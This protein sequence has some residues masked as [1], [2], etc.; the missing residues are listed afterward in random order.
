MVKVKVSDGG[1]FGIQS[2][3]ARL[4]RMIFFPSVLLK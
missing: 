2:F 4:E 1:N 3:G